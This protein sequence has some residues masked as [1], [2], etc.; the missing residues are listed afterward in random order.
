[1]TARAICD[2]VQRA[3][4][5]FRHQGFLLH[6]HVR[7]AI[8]AEVQ[9]AIRVDVEGVLAGVLALRTKCVT[10]A[11]TIGSNVGE[12]DQRGRLSKS[13][14]WALDLLTGHLD[15]EISVNSGGTEVHVDVNDER[16]ASFIR[17]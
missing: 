8:S 5:G 11:I 9:A 3:N 15:V 6:L 10:Q 2:L 13:L 1:L 7:V 4:V 17:T 16:H 14:C 12:R